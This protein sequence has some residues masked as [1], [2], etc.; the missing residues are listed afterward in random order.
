MKNYVVGVSLVLSL[1]GTP[2]ST[3]TLEHG[4]VAIVYF[5][6][7]KII[8]AA[9]SRGL[10]ANVLSRQEEFRN[11]YCKVFVPDGKIVFVAANILGYGGDAVHSLPAWTTQE[12]INRAYHRVAPKLGADHVVEIGT[13][14]AT[15]VGDRLWELFLAYPETV[16]ERARKSKT[17]LLTVALIGGRNAAGE[18]VLFQF[19]IRFEDG[20]SQQIKLETT[21][22]SVSDCPQ[23]FCVIGRTEIA[24]EFLAGTTPRA[25][26]EAATWK[27][28]PGS[29][30]ANV[31]LLR[32][33]RLVEL[34][35]T[36]DRSDEVG[37]PIDSVQLNKDGSL[38]W[39]QRKSNCPRE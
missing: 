33:E 11:D 35:E 19:V 36:F 8:A 38:V 17:G 25:V 24:E 4:T 39:H 22:V 28:S 1:I 5:S 37:G 27:A 10:V 15:E 34:T 26:Q 7:D 9:D 32:T 2:P 16:R 29:S 6:E 12:I 13:A 14:W 3:P 30:G 20:S 23:Q 31:E 18:L 21:P